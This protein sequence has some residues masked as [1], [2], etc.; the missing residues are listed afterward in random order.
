MAVLRTN[1]STAQI[2]NVVPSAASFVINLSAAATA[3]V[4]IGFLV[5]N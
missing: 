3:E 2:K 4:S 1:D 5:I